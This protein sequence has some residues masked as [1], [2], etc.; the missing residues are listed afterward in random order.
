M[1]KENS[2]Q[3]HSVMMKRIKNSPL[4]SDKREFNRNAAKKNIRNYLGQRVQKLS[5]L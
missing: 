3:I 1:K 4:K 2:Q 5:G